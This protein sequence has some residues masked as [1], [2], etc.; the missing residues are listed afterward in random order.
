MFFTFYFQERIHFSHLL[1]QSQY[2]SPLF[3]CFHDATWGLL[4]TTGLYSSRLPVPSSLSWVPGFLAST[5]L[6]R[7]QSLPLLK[8]WSCTRP[9]L[10]LPNTLPPCACP[11]LPEAAG[12]H[13]ILVPGR[14]RASRP[15]L[16]TWT[17]KTK[18]PTYWSTKVRLKEN[19]LPSSSLSVLQDIPREFRKRDRFR[20]NHLTAC[21]FLGARSGCSQGKSWRMGLSHIVLDWM[22]PCAITVSS[23]GVL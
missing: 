22:W 8:H 19:H 2:S 12:R 18:M 15:K 4:G 5:P 9:A 11:E 7:T 21:S 6:P 23:P 17:F 20:H 14:S 13:M 16:D 10:N 1:L 3:L